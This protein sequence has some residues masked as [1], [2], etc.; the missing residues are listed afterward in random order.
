MRA[1]GVP[2][3]SVVGPLTFT[4]YLSPAGDIIRQ[5]NFNYHIH[6][7]DI[8]IY[9]DFD[10]SIPN[11]AACALFRLSNCITHVQ[12]WLI[13]NKPLLNNDKTEFFIAA[14]PYHQKV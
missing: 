14:S 4:M 9:M 5:H 1:M 7:D 8:Q 13:T 2:Q 6:A 3:G 12:N 11:D 10:P